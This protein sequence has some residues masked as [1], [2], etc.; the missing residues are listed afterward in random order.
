MKKSLIVFL[1]CFLTLI[2]TATILNAQSLLTQVQQEN[3]IKGDAFTRFLLNKVNKS[4]L[5]DFSD[6]DKN[7]FPSLQKRKSGNYTVELLVMLDAD[8]GTDAF[9]ESGFNSYAK[10]DNIHAGSVPV[11]GIVDLLNHT[12]V[13]RIEM[14]QKVIGSHDE[15]LPSV[16]IPQVHNGEGLS[17]PLKGDGV[18][19]GII[20]TGIDFNH[21]DFFDDNG[22]RIKYLLDFTDEEIQ[23][24]DNESIDNNPES[25]WH[26]DA[27]GHGTHVAATAAGGGIGNPDYIGVAPE[28]D[29]FAGGLNLFFPDDPVEGELAGSA[30][31]LALAAEMTELADAM[32]QP[33]V[34]N[35]SINMYFGPHDGTS[36]FEMGLAGLA[37]NGKLLVAAAGND[38]HSYM[39]A[40]G[41]LDESEFYEAV[42]FKNQPLAITD[43][44]YTN[45][46]VSEV[47][48]K[49]YN[50][51]TD[52]LLFETGWLETGIAYE[53]GFTIYIDNEEAGQVELDAE[54]VSDPGNSDGRILVHSTV[55]PDLLPAQLQDIV[56]V[57]Q[58]KKHEEND[59][60]IHMWSRTVSFLPFEYFDNDAQHLYGTQFHSVGIPATSHN[61]ISVGSFNTKHT[62][63]DFLG[64]TNHY[65]S[66]PDIFEGGAPDLAQN[67][68][69]SDFSNR[70]PTR[71]GRISPIITGPGSK[72][73]SAHSSFVEFYNYANITDDEH[74]YIGKSGTSMAAPH[75]AGIIALMLQVYPDL[76]FDTAVSI[77]EATATTDEFTGTVPNMIFGWGKINAHAAVILAEQMATDLSRDFEVPEEITL[78][79][80]YPNPFNPVTNIRFTLP[81]NEHVR[82]DLYNVLG[83]RTASITNQFFNAGTHTV[84]FNAEQLASGMYIYRLVTESGHT[85]SGKMT[86]VK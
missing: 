59:G 31:V 43:I 77:L 80:N 40:S 1:L 51:N 34:I 83:Q 76:D 85:L 8:A 70:G 13:R 22:T 16:F 32:Q 29:I 14:S 15:S 39:S 3:R 62:W 11:N 18:I 44:W 81:Q 41:S 21:P 58:F 52:N 30:R 5:T 57:L 23:M 66:I 65:Y 60:M 54:T 25:V 20:D 6:F 4:S 48:L 33:I 75:V 38:A 47:R 78:Y 74:L 28:S 79:Q 63:E 64:N 67:G 17:M 71:D 7:L 55:E 50:D 10:V 19:T 26:E 72:I 24:W 73:F 84:S 56:W 37:D 35:M 61:I 69:I 2:S 9:L 12:D 46:S 36:L 53:E 68:A 27:N 49:M 86:L 45:E 42:Y 82:I